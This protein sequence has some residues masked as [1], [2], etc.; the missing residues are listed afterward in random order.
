MI[1]HYGK[2]NIQTSG[3][4]L[5]TDFKLTLIQGDPKHH[6]GQTMRQG[7]YGSQV[8]NEVLAQVPVLY[9]VYPVVI[10]PVPGYTNG[11]DICNNQQNCHIGCLT[12]GV[13]TIILEKAKLKQL[14]WPLSREKKKKKH[15]PKAMTYSWTDC[16]D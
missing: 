3:R 10:S 2:G 8:L 4:L 6:C 13:N 14:E 12:C 15:K 1:V 5:D 9:P 11:I 16:R 7:A